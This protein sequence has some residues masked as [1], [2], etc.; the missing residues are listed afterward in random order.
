MRR[1]CFVV[2]LAVGIAV[3]ASLGLAQQAPT[4]GP[5]SVLKT[6]K[7]GG[8][9]G[10]GDAGGE[11]GFVLAKGLDGV[12]E[13]A[14]GFILEN[15][16]AGAGL[17]D[18]LNEVVGLVHGEDEDFRGGRGFADLAG[19]FDTV[20]KGHADVENGDVRFVFGGLFDR[21]AAVDGLRADFPTAAGFDQYAQARR[22]S[23][24]VRNPRPSNGPP[25]SNA[26]A[27]C[28]PAI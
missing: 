22:G 19:G 17:N 24:P 15:E 14:V 4:A 21:V 5:Y 11:K 10:F 25:A 8:D 20:E 13:D 16:A 6:V 28:P 18:L 2:T 9:G 26:A 7:V 3:L 27:A 1:F 23:R 12:E